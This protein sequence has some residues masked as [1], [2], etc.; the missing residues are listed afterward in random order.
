M[1]Y[2]NRAIAHQLFYLKDGKRDSV[3][4]PNLRIERG[5]GCTVA[6][7]YSTPIAVY[8]DEGG[9]VLLDSGYFSKT[10]AK[11]QAY[12]RQAIPADV[13][14]IS[15][16]WRDCNDKCW[17]YCC[18]YPYKVQLKRFLTAMEK[19]VREIGKNAPTDYVYSKDR[20]RILADLQGLHRFFSKFDRIRAVQAV[21][22]KVAYI[23]DPVR[24]KAG[25]KRCAA[26]KAEER[27]KQREQQRERRLTDCLGDFFR[28]HNEITPAFAERARRMV[29]QFPLVLLKDFHRYAHATSAPGPD[30]I[31]RERVANTA[32]G[33]IKKAWQERCGIDFGKSC[34]IWL[35][36]DGDATAF[37]TTMHVH[38]GYGEVQRCLKLWK[39]GRIVGAMVDGKYN[40]VRSTDRELVIGCH[41]FPRKVVEAIYGRYA[42]KAE[43]VILKE[44]E[45]VC[46]QFVHDALA[47]VSDFEC[48]VLEAMKADPATTADLDR[49]GVSLTEMNNAA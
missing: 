44:Q 42:G 13:E 39:R 23:N 47:L 33:L 17:R 46:G 45:T 15:F 18:W 9:Y 36:R 41:T 8:P 7:S 34:D 22:R 11:H 4:S 28:R 31:V 19:H 30:G 40:A 3:H 5:M 10:T 1:G 29:E 12:L 26:E 37:V 2:D 14:L 35:A 27:R 48:E 6:Y 21:E 24:I 38:V 20:N 43:E 49:L 16:D 25:Q 32:F